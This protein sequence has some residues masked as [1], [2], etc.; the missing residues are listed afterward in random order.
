[1]TSGDKARGLAVP[2]VTNRAIQDRLDDVVG[3]ENWHNDYKPWHNTGKKESQICG[4]SIYFDERGEW[5]TKWDGAE[6]SD[7]EP[8]KGGLSDSMKRAAVQWGIGRVLYKL[9]NVW[10]GIEPQGR[11]YVIKDTERPKLASAY[12]N[13]LNKLRLSPA[14]PGGM[15][16][17]LVPSP[18]PGQQN[19]ALAAPQT[20]PASVGTQVPQQHGGVVMT[21]PN[22]QRPVWEYKVI[23]A[24]TQ[25]GMS[26]RQTTRLTL[27]DRSGKDI[28]AFFNG[29]DGNLAPGVE[30][31]NVKLSVKQQDSVVFHILNSYSIFPPMNRAA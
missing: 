6:D 24:A 11:S 3:P 23:S 19:I 22:A 15:Q 7:I 30:L 26:G 12:L 20:E 9:P 5:I 28:R 2:Y 21:M 10:V 8:V 27:R 4:I 17:D 29:T 25:P 18:A 13:A 1:M 14:L 16:S 31:V